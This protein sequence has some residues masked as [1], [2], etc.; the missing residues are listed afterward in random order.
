LTDR[1]KVSGRNGLRGALL[2]A[3]LLGLLLPASALADPPATTIDTGPDGPT[4]NNEP[5]F[6]YSSADPGWSE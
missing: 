4:A 3:V 5:S 6:S 1:A 2:V